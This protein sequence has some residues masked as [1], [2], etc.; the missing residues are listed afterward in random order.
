MG[1]LNALHHHPTYNL[2]VCT[3]LLLEIIP[4]RMFLFLESET[5]TIE[6]AIIVKLAMS[7]KT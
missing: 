5:C 6:F 1:A 7:S 2:V 4:K 3:T